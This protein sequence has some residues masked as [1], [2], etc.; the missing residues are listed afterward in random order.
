MLQL[1]NAELSLKMRTIFITIYAAG[2]RVSAVKLAISDFDSK[3][4]VIH[5]RGDGLVGYSKLDSIPRCVVSQFELSFAETLN[6]PKCS[7]KLRVKVM[8]AGV[9][10]KLWEVADI[11]KVL[12]DWESQRG[13]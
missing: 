11:V 1:I 5:V 13:G 3:R 7:T 12:E 10:D 8:A 9:R 2:L 6:L 4:Q